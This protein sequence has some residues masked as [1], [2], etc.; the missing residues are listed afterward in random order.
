M[1]GLQMTWTTGTF[2]GTILL[3][4]MS[5]HKFFIV[6]AFAGQQDF[7]FVNNGCCRRCSY[8]S[9]HGRYLR[10]VYF[11]TPDEG[12]FMTRAM[13]PE[14][15][16][17]PLTQVIKVLKWEDPCPFWDDNYQGYLAR[18]IRVPVPSS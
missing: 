6:T 18:S 2:L 1:A 17:E 9:G 4:K 8:P 3:V 5:G 12:R 14:G 15:P 11:C 10:F 16:W 13:N 7:R